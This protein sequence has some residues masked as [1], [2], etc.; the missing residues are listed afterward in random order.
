MD[1]SRV[2][3]PARA[4]RRRSV[5]PVVTPQR[6][7]GRS[8][9]LEPGSP[10]PLG[11]TWDGRGVNFALFSAHATHVELCLFDARGEREIER[12]ELRERTDE[13]WHG[14]LPEGRPGLLYG[15]RV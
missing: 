2:L 7:G 8:R 12:I 4:R 9:F 5:R 15:Y 6:P 3:A 1:G 10:A 14:Y 13:V 11:A